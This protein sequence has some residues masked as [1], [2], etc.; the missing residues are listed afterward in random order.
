MHRFF[1]YN[2]SDLKSDGKQRASF[3]EIGLETHLWVCK[4]HFDAR[5]LC[6]GNFPSFIFA[7]LLRKRCSFPFVLLRRSMREGVDILNF[8]FLLVLLIHPL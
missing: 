2:V 1:F 4:S 5:F 8:S 7:G 3:T 6:R